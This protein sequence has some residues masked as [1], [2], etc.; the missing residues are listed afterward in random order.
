MSNRGNSPAER[1][2]ATSDG[3]REAFPHLSAWY[4]DVD[5]FL[6]LRIKAREDS[7]YLAIAKG[8]DG[9]GGPV[10]CFGV[11][12]DVA[13]ALMSVDATIQGGHWKVDKPWSA[14]GK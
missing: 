10:V 6:E 4:N 1:W 11:G 3:L 9:K 14:K 8:V 5:E 2:V 12:Y 13:G 7:T